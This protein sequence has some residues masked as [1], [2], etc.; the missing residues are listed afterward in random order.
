[1]HVNKIEQCIKFFKT[2]ILGISYYKLGAVLID[3]ANIKEARKSI[4]N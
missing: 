1:M 2:S 4:K 3:K